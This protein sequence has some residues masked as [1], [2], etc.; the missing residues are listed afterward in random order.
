MS[1]DTVNDLVC[2]GS[3]CIAPVMFALSVFDLSALVKKVP[4][5]GV[6]ECF[7]CT[8]VE[9]CASPSLGNKD[10]GYLLLHMYGFWPLYVSQKKSKTKNKKGK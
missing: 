5:R 4:V 2:N 8:Y 9:D 1:C 7:L 6:I 3:T 10:A